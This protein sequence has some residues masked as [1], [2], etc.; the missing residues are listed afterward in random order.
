MPI[1]ASSV[2]VAW[3]TPRALATSSCPHVGLG[4]CGGKTVL[5]PKP[6]NLATFLVNGNQQA[7]SAGRLLEG[8]GQP[9]EL[10]GRLDVAHGARLLVAIEQHYAAQTLAD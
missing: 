2:P 8:R 10:I 7:S 3:P 9:G 6:G 1:C 5:G 4:R